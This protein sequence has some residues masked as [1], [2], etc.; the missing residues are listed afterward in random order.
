MDQDQGEGRERDDQKYTIFFHSAVHSH[1]EKK[2][3]KGRL[4]LPLHLRLVSQCEIQA[5]A[6]F[7]LE[8]RLKY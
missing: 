7:E 3:Y 1:V 6:S 5:V 8:M 2:E 4:C